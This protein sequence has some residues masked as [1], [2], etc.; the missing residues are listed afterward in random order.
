MR[1]LL[2]DIT[3]RLRGF[4]KQRD[5]IAL[6]LCA[7][8]SDGLPL[9]K[10]LEGLEEESTS[11][12]YWAF[13][14]NFANAHAY[15]NTIVTAFATK[16]E[17]AR[18]AMEKQNMS[19]WPRIP[20]QLLT[21]GSDSAQKLRG[22]VSFSRELLPIH[23]GG[24]NVW[25]FYPLEIA[26]TTAYGTL[27]KEV[28][29]HEF[30]FP[31]CHHIRFIVR[32]DPADR[33]LQV[34]LK[35]SPR[36]DRYEPNLSTD[37]INRSLEAEIAD[38]TLPLPERVAPLPV[39]AG[40]DFAFGRYAEA[41]EKY[42]LLLRYHAPMN[43]STMAAFALNGMGEVYEKVGDL[44]RATESYEAALVPASAGEQPPIPIFLNVV[45]NLGNLCVR[46]SR[47]QEGEEY[48]DLAQQLATVARNAPAK[49]SA[50]DNR[51]VCQKEQGKTEEAVESWNGALVVAAQLEDVQ[52]CR[53]LLGRLEHHYNASNEQAKA[54]QLHE[55][56]A[57]LSA[58]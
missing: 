45:V 39:M 38:E 12:L 13:T 53:T 52:S 37:A 41:L 29:Q 11:D 33:V 49:I 16:H 50:L 25:I 24:N 1:K 22:L 48:Y 20:S 26:D 14:D 9:L 8:S 17:M 21:G 27:M 43:N 32:E 7:P 31:W 2:N 36:V 30:P 15:A 23:N 46:Q 34:I 18:L 57:A 5:N 44:D 6:T 3:G 55:Q 47:W 51:G 56:L 10:I 42:Q 19:P 4:I 28:L 54:E 40:N 35:D 58:P